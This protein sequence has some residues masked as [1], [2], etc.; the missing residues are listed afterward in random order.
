MLGDLVGIFLWNSLQLVKEGEL[1]LSGSRVFF[2]G[3][4]FTKQFRL[5]DFRFTLRRKVITRPHPKGTGHHSCNAGD[6]IKLTLPYLCARITAND[7]E[8]STKPFVYLITCVA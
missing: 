5:K 6:Q 8:T 4:A 2:E 7:S 3:V 1:F